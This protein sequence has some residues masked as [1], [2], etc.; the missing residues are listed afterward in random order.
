MSSYREQSNAAKAVRR[1]IAE[2]KPTAGNKKKPK[3]KGPWKVIANFFGREL[4]LHHCETE[5]LA[6]KMQRKHTFAVRV[7]HRPKK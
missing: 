3:V 7:E 4:I 2:V 1:G 5:E 6:G